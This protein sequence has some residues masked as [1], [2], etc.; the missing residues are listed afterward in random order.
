[1]TASREELA[2]ALRAVC[3]AV[4]VPAP[5]TPGDSVISDRIL[6]VRMAYARVMLESVIG[7]IDG[8]S[9]ATPRDRWRPGSGT[10]SPCIPPRATGHGS[11]PWPRRGRGWPPPA[12]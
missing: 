10:S 2:D 1:M 8:T 11:R 7:I 4:T 5:A 6:V 9:P 12:R 3:E